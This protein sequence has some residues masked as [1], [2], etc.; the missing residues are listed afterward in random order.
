MML[1]HVLFNQLKN[2]LK[3]YFLNSFTKTRHRK[4]IN[5]IHLLCKRNETLMYRHKTT[6]NLETIVKSYLDHFGEK[7]S[8][9]KRFIFFQL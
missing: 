6:Y 4:L 1:V 5:E 8:I 9:F 3:R 2:I 7:N